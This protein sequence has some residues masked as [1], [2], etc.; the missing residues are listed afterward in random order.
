VYLCT[1]M[2]KLF[3]LVTG[4]L[5]LLTTVPASAQYVLSGSDPASL[6]WSRLKGE[7][8]DIIYPTSIDSL[9]RVYLYSLEKTRGIDLEGLRNIETPHMPVIL[10]PYNMYSNGS[11]TWAPRRLELYTTP[12][13]NPL[14]ALDW[15]TQ[16]A[17][18]EGRH[19]GQMTFYTQ[20][21]YRFL[22]VLVG[23][24]GTAVGVG[25]LPSR[26][27]FEGDAV[28]NET[29]FS[30]AGRG[31]DPDFIKYFRAAFLSGDH[32]KYTAWR[33]GS[34]RQ[35]SPGKYPLG[36]LTLSSM[37]DNSGNYYTTADIIRVR[38]KNWWRIFNVSRRAYVAATGRTGGE[39]WVLAVNQNT[40]RWK[41]EYEERAPYTPSVPLS[42]EREKVYTEITNPVHLGD[43]TYAA[44]SGMQFERRLVSFDSLGKRH[45]VRPLATSMS[46][47]VADGD[48]AFLFS[49]VVPDPRW[50][51]RSWSVIR[52]YDTRTRSLATL[53]HRTRFLNPVPSASGDSIVA[54][55]YRVE[56]G[57]NVVILDRDGQLRER[58]PAPENGQV[59]CAVPFREQ[60]YASIVTGEGMGLYRYDGVWHRVV[61]PQSRMIR[62][63][64]AAGDSL[65]YFVSD[66]DGLSNLYALRPAQD[67]EAAPELQRLGSAP[68]SAA[69]PSLDGDGT[70]YY[71][72][73][74]YYGYQPVAIPLDSVARSR[75]SFDEPVVNEVAGRN[76]AQAARFTTPLTPE[77]DTALRTRIDSLESRRYSKLLHGIH[78]HSW[79]P[80]Y[81][82][83]DKLMNDLGGFDLKRFSN[84]Y[85][86]IAP[87]A[88]VISQ[89]NL[90]TLVSTLGYSYHNRHH[91]GHAYLSYSGLYPVFS[92]S[93]D[94]NDRDRLRSVV[95]YTPSG[96]SMQRLDTL[97]QASLSVNLMAALPLNLSRGGWT[98][99]L[100]PQFN[101][102]MTNDA[103]LLVQQGSTTGEYRNRTELVIGTLR[104]DTRVARP[105]ARLTPRLGFGFQASAQMRLGHEL[106]RNGIAGLTAWAYLPGFFKEDG[107]KLTYARQYQPEGSLFYGADYNLVHRCNGY[108]NEILM[109][110]RRGLLEYALPI[111]AGD[112]DGGFFFYLKRINIIPFVDVGYDRRHPVIEDNVILGLAP[113]LFCSYGSKVLVNTRLFRIGSDLQLGVL[114]ARTYDSDKWGSVRFI[115]STG[116]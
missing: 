94:F 107:F 58:I 75:A 11:V 86:Y 18:H 111:Y 49:E 102:A 9:A 96:V 64:Q 98:T 2:R 33:Y 38:S 101:Y 62:D 34:Y 61:D 70:L 81:A 89:N 44:M 91:A 40:E 80:L 69:N 85:E 3:I 68:F 29:D 51:H 78:I 79:A 110:F 55:E 10:H 53:T 74:D 39:N 6:R 12:P 97:S 109:D 66:L 115:M 37:R 76:S 67:P 73:Y 52:R 57:S 15:E 112:I 27:L 47:M 56:G 114:Y 60:L 65:L 1:S 32:R 41:R 88:T 5:L 116:L 4:I 105:T 103:T 19:V 31:R 71:A 93:V 113:K 35:Y 30:A 99:S 87:G 42:R 95:E 104:F 8:F 63:L 59:T 106:L 83:V 24:Q 20:G 54:A 77:E 23:E 48:H 90:G 46:T 22:N 43:R 100:V 16:L 28:L 21:F 45:Y 25:L 26:T 50:E 72:D 92:L 17:L 13:G 82:N 36:Y 14:F 7:H 84:W 108:G